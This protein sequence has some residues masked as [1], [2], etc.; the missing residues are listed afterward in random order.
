MIRTAIVGMGIRGNLFAQGLQ[1]N[2]GA[3]LVSICDANPILQ[4]EAGEKWAVPAFDDFE[5]ML[6][7]QKPDA[8]LVC[9]PDFAH[10]DFVIAATQHGV[11]VMV[12]KPLATSEEEARQMLS[13]T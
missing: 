4:A 8:V 5:Q 10:R 7:E 6:E 9:T 1:Q 3:A 2:P 11:H 13:L 12:E